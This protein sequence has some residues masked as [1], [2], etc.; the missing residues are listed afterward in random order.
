MPVGEGLSETPVGSALIDAS[1]L[2]FPSAAVKLNDFFSYA[3]WMG[4]VTAR[5]REN[6]VLSD[7]VPSS[8]ESGHC[9]T[10]VTGTSTRHNRPGE[11]LH[12]I[13][14]NDLIEIIEPRRYL[15]RRCMRT[16]P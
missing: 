6:G 5:Y 14:D 4:T 7:S 2:L 12:F 13:K 10:A 11:L 15:R 8:E 16:I 1:V 3:G 9:L